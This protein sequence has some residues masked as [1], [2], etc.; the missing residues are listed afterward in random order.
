[1]AETSHASRPRAAS[2]L[3]RTR[4]VLVRERGSISLLLLLVL[5]AW[6][7]FNWY[8][9]L[10]RMVR[11]YTPLPEWD[12]W[13]PAAFLKFYQAFD[14]R[15]LWRQH[16]EH[17]IVFPEIVFALDYLLLHGQ[18]LLPLSMN[19]LCYFG[20][21]LLL[22]WAFGRDALA[23]PIVRKMGIL[24]AG[25][26]IGWQGSAVVLADPFLLQWTLVQFAALLAFTF[27]VRLAET[28][29]TA[30]LIA[31][32]ACTVVAT[33]SSAN[34]LLLWPVVLGAA[35]TLKIGKR[36][37]S[38]MT[39]AAVVSIGVY[40]TGYKFAGTLHI[41]ALV[42]HPLYLLEFV[43]AY[44][45]MPFGAIKRSEF[46]V[47]LGVI[48]VGVVV[49]FAIIA[50][51]NR[52]LASR[53]GIV[54]FGWYVFMLITALMTA[55]GRMDPTERTFSAAKA[56][57]YFTG[58]LVTWAVFILLSLWL[59]SRLHWRFA[60]PYAIT[61]VAA[62]LLLVGLPKLRWWLYGHDQEHAKA[63]TAA[64][65]IEL[66]VQDASVE[67]GIFL[68]PAAV[69]VWTTALRE[70][71]LSVFYQG[72]SKWLGKA[73]DNYAPTL[74]SP[75]PG[76][77]TYTFPVL[78]G[79]ELAGWVDDSQMRGSN[80]W[81]L[82]ANE[83]GRIVGFGRKLPAGFPAVFDNP[84]TPPALGWVGFVNLNYPTKSFSAYAIDRRGLFPIEGSA[85]VPDVRVSTW[86][87]AGPQIR[88]IQWEMDPSWTVNS[89]PP[90]GFFGQGPDKPVY[91]SWS[92]A[93]SNTGRITSSAF[94]AP[95]NA[96]VILPVV[97]GP[98]VAGLSAAVVDAD[99]GHMVATAPL[100]NVDHQW[101]FWRLPLPA[102][103]KRLR[104]FA[105][106]EGKDWGEWL[107]IGNPSQC[108]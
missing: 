104:I 44:F 106:D 97:Q 35:L 80:G 52:M 46:G 83:A 19:F 20:S 70:N 101:V 58:P 87:R 56:A 100:Q 50:V 89:P 55:A 85:G 72:W 95:A 32:L 96:C 31:V 67:L 68:D 16:N 10:A 13:R 66:G 6:L 15:V 29:A 90:K 2:L 94:T 51:R 75:I 81:I 39:M 92:G 12:Y 73:A 103:A 69:D 5:T 57:R 34:G 86:Q 42:R 82:L 4:A 41:G 25:I 8:Q 45:S 98:R 79:V 62:V 54:L 22:A 49:L 76:E 102:S 63:Q 33:Y 30:D 91:W 84:R 36:H 7:A 93:D 74:V 11:Y 28:E 43:G 3:G 23:P 107:A 78:D 14:L 17:R 1:M 24:L 40:F 48:S 21:W 60:R 99:T 64:L 37:L 47:A 27:V 77:I 88:G 105:Q 61:F 9:T 65:A 26:V 18:K 108:N 59:S 53:T 38:A 71:K